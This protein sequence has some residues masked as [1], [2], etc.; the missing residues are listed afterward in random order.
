MI[1]CVLSPGTV[2]GGRYQIVRAIGEGGMGEVYEAMQMQLSRRVALKTIRESLASRPDLLA[3]F[4][5]EAESAAALGHPNLVQVT[6][7]N[8]SPGEPPFL[9]M[10]MLD[11]ATLREVLDREKRIDPPRAAFIGVQLL[12]G[13]AA[14]HRAGI[15][16]RDVKPANVFLQSTSAMR[17]LVKVVD[18]GVA[19]LAL[20]AAPDKPAMTQFGEVLGT[21][22]YMAPEQGVSGAPVDARTDIFAVGATLF[23]ALSG[24]RPLD[25]TEPGGGRLP[26]DRIAPWVHRDLASVID[27]ALA[28]APEARWQS[29]DEMA[30][31]LQAFSASAPTAAASGGW[32]PA[33][34]GRLEAPTAAGSSFGGGFDPTQPDAAAMAARDATLMEHGARA[35]APL[36]VPA[37]S[38]ALPGAMPY[39]APPVH[40]PMMHPSP[41]GYPP[42]VMPVPMQHPQAYGHYDQG[43]LAARRK[44][45][46]LWIFAIVALVSIGV[47][48]P[49]LLSFLAIRNA[50][51]PDTIA[52]NVERE[53]LKQPKQPCPTGDVCTL[54]KEEHGLV[55]PYC[56][57]RAPRLTPYKPGDMVVGGP[58]TRVGLI[59]EDIG[60]GKYVVR[61]LTNQVPQTVEDAD[62]VGRLCTKGAQG[63]R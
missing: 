33:A 1:A 60:G 26:L 10:E 41:Y 15:V 11:G 24:V 39:V 40:A 32:N 2:L 37:V 43:A 38:G 7:F 21:L 34:I 9:V 58:D 52:T 5:R 25:A 14:A 35:P 20:E 47:G 18:F 55:Y 45:P 27:R 30:A 49:Y 22:S 23:H 29:A 50:T 19:K 36:P 57:R 54:S 48:G 46:P 62:I 31:A 13:L 61:F 59:N 56:T 42:G 12:S 44:G 17:D 8:G 51:N 63:G 53:V 16:H 6:D 4:R 3:R 28:K